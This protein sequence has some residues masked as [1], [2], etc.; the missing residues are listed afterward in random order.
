MAAGGPGRRAAGGQRTRLRL[1]LAAAALAAARADCIVRGVTYSEGVIAAGCQPALCTGADGEEVA[2]AD[3]CATAAGA[4]V[5]ATDEVDCTRTGNTWDATVDP[6]TEAAVGCTDAGGAAVAGAADEAACEQTGRAWTYAETLCE[7]VAGQAWRPADVILSS[8]DATTATRCEMS[9]PPDHVLSGTQPGC[10]GRILDT[11]SD[12]PIVCTAVATCGDKDGVGPGTEA[13]SDDDCG[14]GFYYSEDAEHKCVGEFCNLLHLDD[15][16]GCCEPC[17]LV[18]MAADGAAYDCTTPSDSHVSGCADGY[19]KIPGAEGI[20]DNC[21]SCRPVAHQALDGQLMCED[22]EASWVDPATHYSAACA[23]GYYR[24]DQAGSTTGM[25]CSP[26]C[27]GWGQ[28]VAGGG[29]DG[30]V[31]SGSDADRFDTPTFLALQE[32]NGTVVLHVSDTGNSRVVTWVVGQGSGV[33]VVPRRPDQDHVRTDIGAPS[34]LAISPEDFMYVA[35]SDRHRVMK[36]KEGAGWCRVTDVRTKCAGGLGMVNQR[37]TR[38]ACEARAIEIS[39]VSYSFIQEEDTGYA[40]FEGPEYCGVT[41]PDTG[42]DACIS[43]LLP[44]CQVLQEHCDDTEQGSQAMDWRMFSQCG[45]PVGGKEFDPENVFQSYDTGELDEAAEPTGVHVAENGD[46]YVCDKLNDRVVKWPNGAP[47][48]RLVSLSKGPTSS[49]TVL[50][51]NAAVIKALFGAGT[52]APGTGDAVTGSGGTYTGSA[53]AQH[54]FSSGSETLEMRIDGRTET[55]SVELTTNVYSVVAAVD[56]LNLLQAARMTSCNGRSADAQSSADPAAHCEEENG[57]GWNPGEG[58]ISR[59]CSALWKAQVSTTGVRV[60]GG[61]KCSL[62]DR[63]NGLCSGLDRLDDPQGVLLKGNDLYIVDSK[64]HRV[65]QWPIGAASASRVVAG[66]ERGEGLGQLDTPIGIASDWTGA[67]YVVDKNNHRVMRYTTGSTT[68]T[69]AAGLTGQ[70]G[71][72]LNALQF[73]TDVKVDYAGNLYVSDTFNH[74]IVKWCAPGVTDLK[75]ETPAETGGVSLK[76]WPDGVRMQTNTT[77]HCDFPYG[78]AFG[79]VCDM[80]CLPDWTPSDAARGECRHVGTSASNAFFGNAITC[81]PPGSG[82]IDPEAVNYD[83]EATVDDGS[84]EMPPFPWYA[85]AIPLFLMLASGGYWWRKKKK[86]AEVA[87]AE[88]HEEEQR[89][90]EKKRRRKKK[91][92]EEKAKAEEAADDASESEGAA[93]PGE[94]GA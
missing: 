58:Q 94:W 56:A 4:P 47:R 90:K 54:D 59:R 15:L 88:A 24:E 10:T 57:C 65:V 29:S 63:L 39:A 70:P 87:V 62:D 43:D 19:Y 84:C 6:I 89:R 76:A 41:H 64:N 48:I 12:D 61:L 7:A 93:E 3:G 40:E 67:I 11:E 20:A 80:G 46:A 23:H 85:V 66:G 1:A 44:N 31:G 74:R 82:C 5:A 49:I 79:D 78:G 28:L 68:G 75:C 51:S 36:W 22:Y 38:T 26:F 53:F 34:G 60:A 71:L 25:L 72:A 73:P 86:A 8:A 13:V 69:V 92:A 17:T 55:T 50:S 91:K 81:T 33:T 16:A 42:E 77:L 2:V 37:Q 83:P 14:A 52:A 45:V 32:R 18:P 21:T 30:S 35:E 9:C 27:A